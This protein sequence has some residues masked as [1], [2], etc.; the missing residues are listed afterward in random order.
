MLNSIKKNGNTTIAGVGLILGA[1]TLAIE[2]YTSKEWTAEKIG[3]IFTG[4]TGGIG[5]MVSRDGNKS[6]EDVGA[7]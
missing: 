2:C 6:S 1:I 3:I 4:I 5:L 7:K